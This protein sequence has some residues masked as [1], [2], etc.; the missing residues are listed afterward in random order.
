MGYVDSIRHDSF[1]AQHYRSREGRRVYVCFHF[2]TAH[3]LP[4]VVVREDIAPPFV[5]IIRLDDGRHVL[6][7]ECQYQETP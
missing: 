2:D 5:T 7:S 1:P 4:G 3:K 6:A